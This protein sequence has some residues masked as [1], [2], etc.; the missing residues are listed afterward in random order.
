MTTLA[1]CLLLYVKCSQGKRAAVSEIDYARVTAQ[2]WYASRSRSTGVWYAHNRDGVG[3]HRYVMRAKKGQ[4]VDHID[5]Q[6][7]NNVR[8]NLR[9]CTT[10]ENNANWRVRQPRRGGGAPLIGVRP[11]KG[12]FQATVSYRGQ[13]IKG[14]IF[15]TPEEAA[16]DYDRIKVMLYGEFACTH[17]MQGL[18]EPEGDF[19][20][21]LIRQNNNA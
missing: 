18:I 1:R 5:G 9:I 20:Q 11:C 12:G 6:G 17:E 14:G 3:M 10:E 19:A 2:K 15:S 16:R 7:L 13:K 8:E 21:K 4:V